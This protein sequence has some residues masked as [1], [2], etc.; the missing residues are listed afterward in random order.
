MRREYPA[1]QCLSCVYLRTQPERVGDK[2]TCAA[3]PTAI[4]DGIYLRAVDH[5]QPWPGTGASGTSRASER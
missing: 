5:R 1:P 3:Y 4:P 2:A